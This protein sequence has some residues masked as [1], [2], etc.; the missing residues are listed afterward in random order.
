[1]RL[2]TV[3]FILNIYSLL[4]NRIRVRISAATLPGFSPQGVEEW[5]EEMLQLCGRQNAWGSGPVAHGEAWMSKPNEL[6][7]WRKTHHHRCGDLHLNRPSQLYIIIHLQIITHSICQ[8]FHK[9]VSFSL[10]HGTRICS[11]LE[12]THVPSDRYLSR[13]QWQVGIVLL[14]YIH[15]TCIA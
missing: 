4:C 3:V 2:T 11:H 9:L 13:K 7:Q 6:L 10:K 14:Q 5:E 12:L 8:L 1:M 15:E